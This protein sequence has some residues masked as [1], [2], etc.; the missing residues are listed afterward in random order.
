MKKILSQLEKGKLLKEAQ[1]K[2]LSRIYFTT[3]PKRRFR[4]PTLSMKV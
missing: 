4:T 2:I 3:D 1:E